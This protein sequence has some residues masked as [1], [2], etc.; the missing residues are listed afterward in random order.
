MI[1]IRFSSLLSFFNY[2]FNSTPLY[3]NPLYST[4]LYSTLLIPSYSLYYCP[5]RVTLSWILFPQHCANSLALL[6]SLSYSITPSSSIL[7]PLHLSR[8]RSILFLR[9]P[10]HLPLYYPHSIFLYTT[11]TPSS[12]ILPPLHLPLYYP[13]SISLV[14][15]L[16]SFFVSLFILLYYSALLL[17]H[18]FP[19]HIVKFPN[20]LIL[21]KSP[22]LIPLTASDSFHFLSW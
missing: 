2:H 12:S 8:L 20:E 6:Y 14:F 16:S 17:F 9:L 1:T 18:S 3:S 13:H 4:P 11:P 22:L 21:F 19:L 5:S 10:F 7:P 15:A